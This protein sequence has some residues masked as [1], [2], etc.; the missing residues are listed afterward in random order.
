MN[1]QAL[2]EKA[3][4]EFRARRLESALADLVV[5]ERIGYS[6]DECAAA[7]WE[8]WMLLGRFEQAWEES[9]A[10]A[11][12]GARDPH[13]FWDGQPFAG[14]RVII[15]C[16]HGLGDTIQFIRYAEWIRREARSVAVE[17][18]PELVRLL[19]HVQGIDEVF[20]WGGDAPAAQPEWDSQIE[21]NELPRIFRSRVDTIPRDVPYIHVC[22]SDLAC[23]PRKRVGLVWQSSQ[24]NPARS[25]PLDLLLESLAD[26]G[27]DLFSLQFG[28]EQNR[29]PA[30]AQSDVLETAKQMMD[31]DLIIT[32]DTM[33]AHLAGALGL[34]VWVLLPFEADWRWMLDRADSPWYPTMRLFRQKA[35]GDW[36][37][38]LEGLRCQET[39][40]K[41]S[42]S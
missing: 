26:S 30:L 9:D 6:P 37:S 34:P 12:R 2:F 32:V 11:R 5:A 3:G 24:W 38:A 28:C 20:C 22:A 17:C 13:R 27:W 7:R 40:R 23:N 41:S 10:I 19:R 1:A 36:A 25:A 8:C 14:K 21:V 42:K 35:Q 4:E 33:T 39:I 29:I 16:L 18:H 15:R 31:L